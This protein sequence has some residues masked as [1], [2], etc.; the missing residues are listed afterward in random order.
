MSL[1]VSHCS[2][3]HHFSYIWRLQTTSNK[4]V[5]HKR[6]HTTMKLTVLFYIS[7]IACENSTGYFQSWL[8]KKKCRNSFCAFEHD[9]NETMQLH[10]QLF[11]INQST[12]QF[13]WL[14]SKKNDNDILSFFIPSFPSLSPTFSFPP[15]YAFPSSPLYSFLV[16]TIS[17]PKSS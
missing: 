17:S 9:M 15:L 6:I 16:P 8:W 14:K 12:N 2:L 11:K 13:I 1:I 10:T 3:R 4:P 7:I 5:A